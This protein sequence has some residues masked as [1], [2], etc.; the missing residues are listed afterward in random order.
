MTYRR[1]AIERIV[2]S[3]AILFLA[4]SLAFLFLHVI[5]MDV[6]RDRLDAA[7]LARYH[8]FQQQSFGDYLWQ[9]VGRGSLGGDLY[10][11][12][13]LNEPTFGDV[14]VTLSLAGG[15]IVFALL[16]GVPL[17]F[18]WSRQPKLVR[19]FG[20]TFVHLALV[21]APVIIG[22]QLSY[23]LRYKVDLLPIAGYCNFFGSAPRYGCSGPVQWAYH[24]ILP[25]MLL[26]LALAA[27]YTGITRRLLAQV[28]RAEDKQA[29]HR[30]ALIAATKLI[31]RN[32]SWLLGATVI[33]ESF[34]N[35]H[36]LG[37]DIIGSV[38][39]SNPPL[40]QAILLVATIAAVGLM[41]VV[42]LVAAAFVRDW[43]TS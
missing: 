40:A 8:R 29:A 23:L 16:V 43:R 2:A 17:G 28:G 6:R 3:L 13:D 12:V 39:Q 30:A 32:A 35:F 7:G 21:L 41:L 34:F 24:L 36:G 14:P 22:L 15:A 27:V 5:G 26:G 19:P 20:S 11:G 37:Q 38:F 1:Y 18:A 10:T 4:A 9:L 31:V 33:V 42:D 25:S